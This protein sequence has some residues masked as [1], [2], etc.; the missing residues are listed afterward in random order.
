MKRLL[1]ALALILAV[2]ASAQQQPT[3]TLVEGQH[4]GVKA[5]LAVAVQ[6]SR[7]W[8]E[9]WKQHGASEPAPAVDFSLNSVVV[10]FLGQTETAGVKVT[11]VVQQDP[12]DS[13]RLNVFYRRTVAKKAMS[14]QVQCQPYAMVLVPHADTIDIEADAPAS[15]PER[16]NAPAAKQADSAK[17]VKALL[18]G[19]SAFE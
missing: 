14:A 13:S 17:R 19:F 12:I 4:S 2:N 10:V 11:V 16:A 6:D 8:T 15:I 1:A 18:E 7:K 3:K 9:I 5:P